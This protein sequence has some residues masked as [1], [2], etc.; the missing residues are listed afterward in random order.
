MFL[1]AGAPAVS[2]AAEV[3][4]VL[5]DTTFDENAENKDWRA[6][7]GCRTYVKGD[8]LHI[9]ALQ[10]LPQ[11]SR[12]VE[13][14]GGEFRLIVELRTGTESEVSLYWMRRGTLRRDEDHKI[15]MRLTEDGDWN[16]Y[17]FNFSV[18]DVLTSMMLRF[19]APDGAW[20]IRS[21]KLIRTSPPPLSV[22]EVTPLL[23]KDQEGKEREG[24]RFTVSNDLFVT[25][26]YRI[27]HQTTDLTLQHGETVNLWAPIQPEGNLAA[28]IL[29]LH[30]QGFPSQVYPVFLYHPEGQTDWIQKPVGDNAS[31]DNIIVDIA[32]DARMARLRRGDEVFGIIAP[33]VHRNGVIPQFVLA[34]DSTE[35][36]LYFES[37]DVDLRISIAPPLLNFEI[38]DKL[39][40]ESVPLEGPVVR[41]FGTLQSGL[42]PGVEFL[43]TGDTSS[44]ERDIEKPHNERSKPNPLWITMPFAVLE[45]EKGAVALYWE[46]SS[47]QPTF[48]SPNRFDHT[49]D[50]RVSLIGS[51]VGSQIKA[52]LELLPPTQPPAQ[53]ASF[54]VLRSYVSRKGFPP[55]PPPLRTA[56]EQRLLFVQ[57]LAGGLQSD[58]GGQW[59]YAVESHWER[60]PFADMISTSVRLTEATGEKARNPNALVPGGS[61]ISND[62]IYFLLGRIPE[63]QQQREA[64]IQQMTGSHNA[65]GSFLFRTRFPQLETAASSYGYT[66]IQALAIMEYVRITGN[67]D[68]FAV[69][70]KALEFLRSCDIPCGGY[71]RDTLFSTPDLQT[72][73]TLVWLY[74]WAYEYSGNTAFLDRAKHFAFA[75]LPFVYQAASKEHMLYGTVGKFGGTNRRLPIFFGVLSPQVGIQYAYALNLLSKHDDETDWK[76]VAQGILQAAENL[77]YTEGMEAGCVPELFDVTKQERLGEKVNPC[78]LV[79]LRWAVD[80][81]VDS[82][83][84]LTDGRAR[85]TAPYP[86]RKT[87]EGIEAYNVPPGQKFRILHNA[88]RYGTGE[89]N[90]L[91]TV[92]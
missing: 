60:K 24:L 17:E 63:W 15:Q 67:D 23:R 32:P 42:L 80:G 22:R 4:Q 13:H 68:L 51:Q 81:K 31:I 28:V 90:G 85:Y 91:I 52:S 2:V 56:E 14:T 1:V 72:A 55:P 75:G 48:S 89:G 46:D 30:P 21:I 61:D 86:L 10:D 54:R 57:A 79:S 77:Q 47:L 34:N 59:G 27:G 40:G 16:F 44:S 45:T 71:Y 53:A 3:V 82:L 64:A 20:D 49:Q 19:S 11:L 69:V 5:C 12:R 65:D 38:T 37:N 66:A 43:K 29:T 8:I 74:V 84:V 26:P 9:E 50:H 36:E 87:S 35:S 92:D 58:M 7:R 25:M 6:E 88:R 33:L 76:T 70:K 18:P 39:E 62:A 83:F 73:A 41:F 78:A